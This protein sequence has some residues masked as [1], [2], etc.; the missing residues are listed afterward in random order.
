MFSFLCTYVCTLS[1]YP[2]LHFTLHFIDFLLL[3]ILRYF[4][5]F[6]KYTYTYV[7]ICIYT[8]RKRG[9]Q[10]SISSFC[11]RS[12]TNILS[13]LGPR[14]VLNLCVSV[15]FSIFIQMY[16]LL[17]RS[18]WLGHSVRRSR[19]G[20]FNLLLTSCLYAH[21]FIQWIW[22]PLCTHICKKFNLF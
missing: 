9:K 1:R 18:H 19:S 16:F 14:A 22:G 7:H 17:A 6:S 3:V 20:P 13:D 12:Y 2:V 11:L 8:E 10:K 21:V 4:L 15:D 5:L